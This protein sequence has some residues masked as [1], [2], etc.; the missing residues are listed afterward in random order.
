ML[1]NEGRR[2]VALVGCVLIAEGCVGGDA[3]LDHLETLPSVWAV[4]SPP[5]LKLGDESS[6]AQIFER[7]AGVHMDGDGRIVVVDGGAAEVRLFGSDGVHIETWGGKGDGPGEYRSPMLLGVLGGDTLVV[8]DRQNQVVDVLTSS[9][10][11]ARSFRFLD[12]E[13]PTPKQAVGVLSDGRVV[14]QLVGLFGGTLEEGA[15]LSDTIRFAVLGAGGESPVMMGTGP[16]PAWIW[17]GQDQVP[18]PFSPQL[19]VSVRH[20]SVF[21]FNAAATQVKLLRPG[22][23]S[24]SWDAPRGPAAVTRRDR[25]AYEDAVLARGLSEQVAD[26]WISALQHPALPKLKPV[27]DLVLATDDG[28]VW[29]RLADASTGLWDVYSLQ[30]SV[31][32]T[33]EFPRS[34]TP[35]QVTGDRVV[36]VVRD[37]MGVQTVAIFAKEAV[38]D[39]AR[40]ATALGEIKAELESLAESEEIF[41]ADYG[42][43]TDHLEYL[44]LKHP[45]TY[46]GVSVVLTF[47]GPKGWAASATHAALAPSEGCLLVRPERPPLSAQPG[48]PV[49]E[50]EIECSVGG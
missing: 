13:D 37:S 23:A 48:W 49:T 2:A 33:V 50:G 17:T 26:L 30:G 24:I 11:G 21:T 47:A 3:E 43:Y 9:G 46:P 14:Y 4:L 10:E 31:R 42:V 35:Y 19:S 32:G 25:E 34:A 38:R 28:E 5:L 7:V 45:V 20:D 40:I 16:V 1:F 12:P 39:A 8:L 44:H 41:F 29:A 36:A 18:M 22:E 27:Y 6:E 15:V